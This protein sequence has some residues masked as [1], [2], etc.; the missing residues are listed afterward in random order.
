MFRIG[1]RACDAFQRSCRVVQLI[2]RLK[3]GVTVADAQSEMDV[4]AGQLVA[5]HPEFNKGRGIRVRPARGIR[6]TEQADYSQSARLLA[7]AVG[8]V[9]LAACAN[10]SGL[11]LAR[12][13]R[14][15]REIAVR[16]ALGSGRARLIRQLLIESLLLA[17]LGGAAGLLVATW[18]NDLLAAFYG[19][20]YTGGHVDFELGLDRPA[21]GV[22]LLLSLVTTVLFGL[23]P[24]LQ[25]G[26]SQI[27]PVLKD[28]GPSAG[29]GRSRLRD[30]LIVFQMALTAV[31]VIGA[32]LLVQSVWHLRRGPGLDVDHVALIRL[33]PSLVAYDLPKARAFHEAVIQRLEALPGVVS[34]S[35]AD[36]P[37]LPGWG[38]SASVSRADQRDNAL[39]AG[40][41]RVGPR[42]FKTLDVP[43]IEGREFDDRD[44]RGGPLSVILNQSLANRLAP[45]APMVG[46]TVVIE[47]EAHVVLGVARDAQYLSVAEQARPFV[48]L[49]YWQ[50]NAVAASSL[51]SRMHVRVQ[52]DPRAM[53]PLIRRAIVDVDPRVPI[54]EVQAL[55]DRV[56]FA[57]RTVRGVSRILVWLGGVA[58]FLGTIGLYSVLSFTVGQRTR[59]IAIR[60]ALGATRDRITRLVISKGAALAGLGVV[61]GLAGAVVASRALASFLYGIQSFDPVTFLL[62]PALLIAVA[63]AASYAPARRAARVDPIVAL[64]AE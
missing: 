10:V 4:L 14:R 22:S 20:N 55:A 56:A 13:V 43:V 62:V 42:Y 3:P 2:G 29:T 53:L 49:N 63:L 24:A 5:A 50:R 16:Q 36:L 19:T 48:Y 35:P 8:L 17:L 54:S 46:R 51:D 41:Q 52:G 15:R 30:A 25:A 37:P 44:R 23:V 31:L 9:L 33:W 27:V 1:Y 64:R 7:A 60:I 26:R 39:S 12:G 40:V 59:E 58:V 61:C 6:L 34:A 38:G 57:F 32:A 11:L 28:E 45:G 47:G 18:T 21:L